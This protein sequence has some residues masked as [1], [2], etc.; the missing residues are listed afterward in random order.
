MQ[1]DNDGHALLWYIYIYMIYKRF[2][3]LAQLL[4]TGEWIS[5][6]EQFTSAFNPLNTE[7]NPICQ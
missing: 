2:Q 5:S 4:P 1:Q 7:L 6:S 3:L